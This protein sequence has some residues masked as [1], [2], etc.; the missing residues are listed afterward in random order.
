[1]TAFE[2]I[3]NSHQKY[4]EDQYTI[5]SLVLCL[6]GKHRVTYI[7]KKMQNGGMFWDV[8]TAA[9]KYNGEKKYLKSYSQDSNF[10][11][12]DIMH[13]L[14]NRSWEKGGS[15]SEKSEQIPF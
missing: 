13:F 1:M 2:Y 3:E 6:D 11:K 4:P 15:I 8:I 5:E 9:V 14:E 10:L 12:E 7:R